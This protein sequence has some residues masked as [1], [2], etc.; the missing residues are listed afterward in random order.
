MDA[1]VAVEVHRVSLAP[2]FPATLAHH[3]YSYLNFRG[4]E[5]EGLYRVPGSGPKIKEWQ[6]RF[7]KGMTA[8]F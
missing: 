2:S 1:C 5:E 7:D 4:C 3:R 6:K 8:Q